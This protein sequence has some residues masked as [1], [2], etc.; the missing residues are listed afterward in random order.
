MAAV[1]FSPTQIY[2]R[3]I[4]TS[5]GRFNRITS[6]GS[7]IRSTRADLPIANPAANPSKK[8]I[9]KATTTRSK[10]QAK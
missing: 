7:P 8:A 6:H 4:V 2:A 5:A 9:A 1:S 3:M 10:V